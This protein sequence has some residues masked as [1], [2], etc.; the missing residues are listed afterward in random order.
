MRSLQF[1]TRSCRIIPLLLLLSSVRT[2]ASQPAPLEDTAHRS[3]ARRIFAPPA[4]INDFPPDKEAARKKFEE[5][6]SNNVQHW[7]EQAILGDPW[8]TFYDSPRPAYYSPLTTPEPDESKVVRVSWFPFPNR[9]KAY[10]GD[11]FSTEELYELA[12]NGKLSDGRGLPEIPSRVCPDIDLSSPLKPYTP[13]GPRGWQ[14]EYCEWSVKRDPQTNN[15]LSVMFTAEN[16]DYWRS[17]WDVDPGLVVDLYRKILGNPR[18]M[19]EDLYLRKNGMV[20]IDPITSQPAYDVTNKW[21]N[22]TQTLSDRGGAV[23]L[24]S[25][26]NTLRAQIYIAASA[27]RLRKNDR[28]PHELLCAFKYGEYFRNSD[29]HLSFAVNQL[30]KNL[31][32]RVSLASPVGLYI[33]E[34]DFSR[35]T[36]PAQA[37]KEI[38]AKDF[39]TVDRGSANGYALHVI[40]AVPPAYGFTVSDIRIDGNP[41]HWAAQI[42]ETFKVGMNVRTIPQKRMTTPQPL[43]D[44]KE[45]ETPLAQPILIAGFDILEALATVDRDTPWFPVSIKRGQT[46]RGLGLACRAASKNAVVQVVEG[47]GVT[48]KVTSVKQQPSD[49]DGIITIFNLDVSVTKDAPVGPRDIQVNNP[50]ITSGPPGRGFLRIVK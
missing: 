19:K 38:T 42:V 4:N 11:T 32:Q 39:W 13:I 36:L 27:S 47:R 15:I 16:P 25:S 44:V 45:R 28:T 43:P 50:G 2:L 31:N 30:V 7:T 49:F 21:N 35:Y 26:P 14:D 1:L 41:I 3:A 23:H 20:V 17:L 8:T 37:P 10:F 5:L 29:P 6:W 22:G 18:V 33:Q 34:P 12:D 48:V 46:I 24:T 40:F 9:F